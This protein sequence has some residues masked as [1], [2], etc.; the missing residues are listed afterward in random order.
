VDL[1]LDQLGDSAELADIFGGNVILPGAD[2]IALAY[3]GHQFG[4]FSPQ[5]GDGRAVLLGDVVDHHGRRYDIQLK[6]SGRTPFSRR[7]DGK[8]SL[9]P[10]IR[11]FLVSEAMHALGV[12]TT[13][14]LAAVATGETVHRETA[15]PGGVLTR[16]A[17]S[18]IRIGT[19]EYFAAR[20]DVAG[21]KALADFAIARHAP[22]VASQSQPYLALFER[23]LEAQTQLVAHWMSIGFIHGV[24]NTD[25]MAIS[26]ETLDYGPCAF[27]D[28]FHAEKVFSS[29]DHGGR[30][31]FNQQP[32]IVHWNLT[33]LAECLLLLDEDQAAFEL[34]LARV[35]SL[36]ESSYYRRMRVK[37][38]IDDTESDDLL[39]DNE[40]VQEWLGY[41][42]LH[43]LDYTQSFRALADQLDEDSAPR[44]GD[45]ETRWLRR[46]QRQ[47]GSKPD[48][49]RSMNAVNPMFIP[50]NHQIE[51]A[52]TAGINADY[53]IFDELRV[54]LSQPFDAQ[55]RYAQYA[56]PPR[57][58]E[59]VLR[60][61]CGT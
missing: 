11:E 34:Q 3:A 51:R 4:H 49:R 27:M 45:F 30:Y 41:L 15:L 6:G 5:L 7:G 54:A 14:A 46:V 56:V 12:P 50:R 26:G 2:P 22:N 57:P 61:Y 44:F 24:M 10:V 37:L 21:V 43:Q 31:A 19:F 38:G 40:L 23:V 35:K 20:R 32:A 9:G 48:T 36:F 60:T 16:I 53:S 18:H 39:A 55:E 52:I 8:S 58:E 29:I 1:G 42:Q 13:R 47:P 28:A 33:R 25:N 17:S 59:Q